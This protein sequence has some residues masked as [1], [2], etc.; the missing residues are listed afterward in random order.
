MTA[1]LSSTDICFSL[2]DNPIDKFSAF[3]K[4]MVY[5]LYMHKLHDNF[6][7]LELLPAL[8]A[9]LELVSVT[10]AAER[11]GLSQPAM[12]RIVARLRH[13]FADPLLVRAGNSWQLTPRAEGLRGPVRKLLN[14][15]KALHEPDAFDPAQAEQSFRVAIPDVIGTWLLPSLHDA[16][17]GAA[18]QCRLVVV[19]WP[20][21]SRQLSDLDLA[22][23]SEVQMFPAFRMEPLYDDWDVLAHRLGDSPP[24]GIEAL[25]HPHVAVIPSGFRSDL[26]DDWLERE[27]LARKISMVV[28]HYLQALHLVGRTGLLAILPNRLIGALGDAAGV[29]ALELPIPQALDRQWIF[30]PPRLRTD[31]AGI[32]LRDLVRRAVSDV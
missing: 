32:W 27:G 28:P 26:V 13:E 12:S 5:I 7:S 14:D 11:Q 17:A 9:V 25:S 30:Y 1:L 6:R 19:P 20:E 4:C 29:G 10:R 24:M 21:D 15:A 16:F 2:E 18:P 31:P 22:I 3:V 23:G 8:D